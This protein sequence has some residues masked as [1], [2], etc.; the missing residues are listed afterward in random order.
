MT[1]IYLGIDLGTTN[2]KV[3]SV[4]AEGGHIATSSKP[5]DW[6][7]KPNG[8]IETI[9]EDIFDRILACIDD[10]LIETKKLVPNPKVAGIGITGMAESGVIL[11]KNHQIIAQPIAWF[12]GRGEEE[13]LALGADFKTEYQSKT[14]LVFKPESSL[15]SLLS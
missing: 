1:H 4:D 11:D 6:I 7:V 15:S 12:D 5:T 9:S 14:G 10:L 13:M 2:T 8:R 3:I